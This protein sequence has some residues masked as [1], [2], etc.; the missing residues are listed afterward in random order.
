MRK[1]LRQLVN[2]VRE[3]GPG[4]AALWATKSVGDLVV[5]LLEDR[6][7]RVEAEALVLG[8]AHRAY[9]AHSMAENRELWGNFAWHER[10]EEWTESTEWK[11]SLIDD[12]LLRY[13]P[14][15]G[16]I[17]EIGPGAGRWTVILQ[18]LASRLLI[19]DFEPV[20]TNCLAML[21]ETAN[22]EAIAAE[23]EGLASIASGSVSAVWSYDVFVHIAPLDIVRY[24]DELARILEPG[25]RAVIHHTRRRTR[26]GWQSPMTGPL[27]A[28]L[29][30]KAGF[31]VTDQF[32]RWGDETYGV[33]PDVI[34]VLTKPARSR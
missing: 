16:V 34:S 18:R 19:V 4:Y 28:H 30:R 9:R 24:I 3:F 7:L 33:T 31:D 1:A 25:A 13:I 21:P 23:R 22:I 32:S 11:Q 5:Y 15:G 12:V 27:F 10:G 8:P 2:S 6:L 26:R 14:E 29:A 17:M 20:L